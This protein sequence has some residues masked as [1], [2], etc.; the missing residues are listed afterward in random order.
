MLR[1]TSTNVQTF[2]WISAVVFRGSI[3]L[4]LPTASSGGGKEDYLGFIY[5]STAGKWDLLAK[6]FGF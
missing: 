5:D 4:P 6:N 3:D 1:L 2:N